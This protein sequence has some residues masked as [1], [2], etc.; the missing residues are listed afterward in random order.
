MLG[1]K[2]LK[3][4]LTLL[5]GPGLLVTLCDAKAHL[6]F[7]NSWGLQSPFQLLCLCPT[8]HSAKLECRRTTWLSEGFK[9]TDENYCS[10]KNGFLKKNVTTHWQSLQSHPYQVSTAFTPL[11]QP[12]FHCLRIEEWF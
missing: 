1:F 8:S 6:P 2:A 4:R 3:D 7:R 12:P 9:A 11:T 5:V 10:E